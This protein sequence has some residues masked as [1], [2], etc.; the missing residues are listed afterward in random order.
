MYPFAIQSDMH[1][2]SVCIPDHAKHVDAKTIT[3]VNKNIFLISPP[4]I[5]SSI[6]TL[7]LNEKKKAQ[8]A[9]G[10]SMLKGT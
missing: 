4:S 1:L 10:P 8:V 9:P 2:K 6:A 3:I 7:V 5:T